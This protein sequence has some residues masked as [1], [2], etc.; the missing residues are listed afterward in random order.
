NVL[1]VRVDASQY[2]GW[3]YEGAGIYRHVWLESYEQVHIAEDGLFVYST[4]GKDAAT[5][6]M[7]TTVANE[8][9]LTAGASVTC[10][11]TD[12][13]GRQIGEGVTAPVSVG[14]NGSSVSRQVLTVPR[15]VLWSPDSPY[16]YRA[17][18][19]VHAGGRVIDAQKIR[20]GIRRIWV[21]SS[22]LYVNG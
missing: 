14:P 16:L 15:P 5:V 2:E 8:G 21:D 13:D 1:A 7:E 10:F 22:G 4:V 19:V 9:A 20:I 12:R 11:I 6:T 17:M 18:A 3:Y